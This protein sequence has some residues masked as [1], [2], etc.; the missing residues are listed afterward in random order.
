V[1][2]IPTVD[3]KRVYRNYSPD[4][5]RKWDV[6]V[7]GSGMG[8]MACA[9]ALGKS[10][11]KV[12]VLE[13]H[14]VPG[15]FTHMFARKGF[16]WDAGVHAMG[17]MLPHEIPGK[18]LRWLTDGR[19]EMLPLGDPYDRFRFH[20]G[21]EWGLPASRDAWVSALRREFPDRRLL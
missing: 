20:D 10:G 2:S 11:R 16:H 5:P 7:V 19:V 4:L 1:S 21:F 8:G 15:G 12:L 14:Y 18:V 17:E 6:V 9:T 3:G 13:Q